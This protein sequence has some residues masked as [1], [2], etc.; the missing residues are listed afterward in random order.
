MRRLLPLLLLVS[1]CGGTAAGLLLEE[2]GEEGA[3]RPVSAALQRQ[4][5]QD[6]ERGYAPSYEGCRLRAAFPAC[7]PDRGDPVQRIVLSH[8][9]SVLDTELLELILEGSHYAVTRIRIG[10]VTDWWADRPRHRTPV[11]VARGRVPAAALAGP[12]DA[13]WVLLG[14]TLS[15]E[16][17]PGPDGGGWGS[18][19]RNHAHLLLERRSSAMENAETGGF[20]SFGQTGYLP[21]Y[22]AAELLVSALDEELVHNR[23]AAPDEQARAFFRHWYASRQALI[24]DSGWIQTHLLGAAETLGSRELAPMILEDALAAAR[25]DDLPPQD[26]AIDA[27]AALTGTDLRR[28]ARHRTQILAGYAALLRRH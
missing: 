12:L 25:R 8:G 6:L 24:R 7:L 22:R 3:C 9:D 13:A 14:T 10:P 4:L 16:R 11:R 21:I 2:L 19:G 20:G 23:P 27:L 5:M 28:P 1:G 18:S 17:P 26:A 15:E